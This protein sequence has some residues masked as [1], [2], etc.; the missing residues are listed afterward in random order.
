MS[1]QTS[2]LAGG[3]RSRYAG[4]NVGIRVAPWNSNSR[5]RSLVIG[6]RAAQQALRRE[7]AERDDHA[8]AD[9]LD[10]AEQE[11]LAGRHLVRL[12]I[13]IARRAA[14]DHVGDVDL[15]AG[16]ADRLDDLR[17]QLPGAADEG[18]ALLV[19]VLARRLAHEHQPR[20]RMAD[21]EHHLA[22]SQLAQLAAHALRSDLDLQRGERLVAGERRNVC[23]SWTSEPSRP[24]PRHRPGA[25]RMTPART[26]ARPRRAAASTRRRQAGSRLTPVTP[27]SAKYFRCSASSLDMRYRAAGCGCCRASSGSTRSRMRAATAA[28]DCSGTSSAWSAD[29]IVTAL[30]STSK[31]ASGRDTSLATM[32]SAFLRD[33]LPRA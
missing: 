10:L 24:R 3:L 11:R 23:R 25:R 9:D 32:R 2:R 31:P 8:R 28:F 20:L 5:P 13:A 15:L 18:L 17:Q 12:G 21:A 1:S 19:F 30:V 14:L 27:R 26:R 7:L 33:S 22:P 6:S 4:W 29:T 16:Q